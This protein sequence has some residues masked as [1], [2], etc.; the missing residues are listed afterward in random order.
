MRGIGAV[1]VLKIGMNRCVKGVIGAFDGADYKNKEIHNACIK[2]AKH[3][4]EAI[5]KTDTGKYYVFPFLR[6]TKELCVYTGPIVRKDWLDKLNMEVPETIQEWEE[7]LVKFRDEMGADIPL[8]SL[9][10]F[11]NKGFISSAFGVTSDFFVGN[12]GKVKFG[13]N[14]EGYIEYLKLMKRWYDMGILDQNFASIDSN[15]L[16]TNI[17]S[18]RTGATCHNAGGGL[19]RWMAAMETEDS[20][21]E[22]VGAPYPVLKKGDRPQISIMEWPYNPSSSYAISQDCKNVEL[23][24]RWLDYGYSEEGHLTYNFGIED[25]SYSVEENYPTLTELI[26]NNPDGTPM[27]SV[28]PQYVM[29]SYSGPFVQDKRL[30]DQTQSLSQQR[31]AASTWADTDGDK[32]LLPLFSYTSEE[33]SELTTIRADLSTYVNEMTFEFI[34]GTKS[35]DD[36]DSF[37]EQLKAMKLERALEIMNDALKRYNNR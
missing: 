33:L 5:V 18:S 6:E 11:L 29:G 16:Q 13:P 9:G 34:M 37:L 20:E 36:Y 19:A 21:F 31:E 15:V 30:V 1:L 28:L 7:M 8:S 26:T 4:N 32:H 25:V 22:L 23:A 35:L 27:T 2:E 24:A 12:D 17:L 14:E 10:S 3:I